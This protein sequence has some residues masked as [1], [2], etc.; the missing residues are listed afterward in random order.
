MSRRHWTL[1]ARNCT[2][3]FQTLATEAGARQPE[4]NSTVEI[5]APMVDG[6]RQFI[7]ARLTATAVGKPELPATN[8]TA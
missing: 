3:R 7:E 6:N 2:K 5:I 8:E 4:V 1:A